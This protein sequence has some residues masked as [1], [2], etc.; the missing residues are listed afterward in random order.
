[1]MNAQAFIASTSHVKYEFIKFSFKLYEL[2]DNEMKKIITI[3]VL[4]TLLLGAANNASAFFW[5][6]DDD[7]KCWGPMGPYGPKLPDCIP[8]DE[9][10][11]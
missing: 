6:D 1:M 10:D 2:G 4:S 8:Y 9:L 7:W 11:P 3:S 5:D